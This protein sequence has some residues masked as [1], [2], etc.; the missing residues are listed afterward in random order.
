MNGPFLCHHEHMF[1]LLLLPLLHG[2]I[3]TVYMSVTYLDCELN[4]S[5]VSMSYL[6]FY[7]QH[8]T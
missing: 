2:V 8:L 3:I 5:M 1:I 7:P 6:D 4:K